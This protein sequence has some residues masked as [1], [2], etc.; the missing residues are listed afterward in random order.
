MDYSAY[1][2]ANERIVGLERD[3]ERLKSE[4]KRARTSAGTA[5][6]LEPV[7]EPAEPE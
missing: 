6:G 4:L 1:D 5:G 3:V 2:H 7:R